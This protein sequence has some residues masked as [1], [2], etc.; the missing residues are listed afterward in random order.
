M[1]RGKQWGEQFYQE[2]QVL[3]AC[4]ESL[5]E[6]LVGR[7]VLAAGWDGCRIGFRHNPPIGG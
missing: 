7:G 5:K 2:A 3:L 1:I 4:S 6:G